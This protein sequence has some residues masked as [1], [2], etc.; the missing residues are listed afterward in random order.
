MTTDKWLVG[1]LPATT[2][3]EPG[4]GFYALAPD[5]TKYWFEHLVYTQAD[6]MMKALWSG[7][8]LRNAE[9]AG[10]KNGAPTPQIV[11]DSDQ[12]QRR[13]AAL[14][15]TRVEDR[16]GNWVT[17][18]YTAG[19]LTSIDASDGRHVGLINNNGFITSITVGSGPTSRTWSYNYI[20]QPATNW[21]AS[22]TAPD[23]S[24][25][26]YALGAL[27]EAGPLGGEGSHDPHIVLRG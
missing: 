16:F 7:S 9:A 8:P 27:V 23:G 10:T 2:S 1:C 20:N 11:G 26:Q 24:L 4:E 6:T 25:W 17:Y 19:R 13:Y 21:L 15:V 22:V 12:L 14:L 18:S 3:G 5:G